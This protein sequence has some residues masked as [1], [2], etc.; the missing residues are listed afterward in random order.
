MDFLTDKYKTSLWALRSMKKARGQSPNNDLLL[1]LPTHFF[2]YFVTSADLWITHFLPD[3]HF[4]F[5]DFLRCQIRRG[6]GG[7]GKAAFISLKMKLF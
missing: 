7:E 5:S 6:G 3:G 2:I 1:T 4:C